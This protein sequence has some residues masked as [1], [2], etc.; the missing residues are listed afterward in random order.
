MLKLVS[1]RYMHC[2]CHPGAG[3]ALTRGG[4]KKPRLNKHIPKNVIVFFYYRFCGFGVLYLLLYR[5]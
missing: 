4:L 2:S 5:F 3:Q 1:Q